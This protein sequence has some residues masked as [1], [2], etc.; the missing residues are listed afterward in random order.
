M[1]PGHPAKLRQIDQIPQQ[2]EDGTYTSDPE[3]Q[4]KARAIELEDPV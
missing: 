4:Q 3:K 2:L 1:M